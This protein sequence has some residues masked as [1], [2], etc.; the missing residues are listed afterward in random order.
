[1]LDSHEQALMMSVS[2]CCPV[3]PG[4]ARAGNMAGVSVAS[5]GAAA[6]IAS[7]TPRESYACNPEL[8]DG[9]LA[10]CRGFLLQCGLVFSQRPHVF[11]KMN[12]V[13]G[14]LRRKALACAQVSSSH[15]H[16]NTLH[17]DEFAKWFERIFDRPNY[18][19]CSRP[20]KVLAR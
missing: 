4:H 11:S 9:D 2:Q 5:V 10:K 7:P 1:M 12:Y 15:T 18:S 6:A 20:S 19:G 17:F 3:N 16:L 8:F 13:I 14:L